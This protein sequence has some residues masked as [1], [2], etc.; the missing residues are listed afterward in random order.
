ME[1]DTLDGAVILRAIRKGAVVI[2][3]AALAGFIVGAFATMA[4]P[5]DYESYATV[6][7]DASVVDQ[8][9]Q[10]GLTSSSQD[11][12]L[13]FEA[14]SDEVMERAGQ[15]VTPALT[16]RE[17]RQLI[18]ASQVGND[19]VIELVART[20]DPQLSADLVNAVA[21]SMLLGRIEDVNAEFDD[22]A[23]SLDARIAELESELAALDNDIGSQ[24]DASLAIE[25]DSV[26]QQLS[27][28]TEIEVRAGQDQTV[29]A[30][31]EIVDQVAALEAELAILD[32]Q[33]ADAS[34]PALSIQRSTLA[35][36]L[37]LLN[38][39]RVRSDL[40]VALPGEV[41]RSGQVPVSPVGT[42][43]VTNGLAL[44]LIFGGLATFGY[45][46]HSRTFVTADEVQ[47]IVG[48]S[49]IASFP[50]A[51][52]LDVDHDSIFDD[53]HSPT[54]DGLRR[55]DLWTRVRG[56][57]RVL[58]VSVGDSPVASKLVR[59]LAVTRRGDSVTRVIDFEREVLG[60]GLD[61][62]GDSGIR[63][64]SVRDLARD[65]SQ[66]PWFIVSP[67]G[68]RA[69]YALEV[70]AMAD[71]VVLVVDAETASFESFRE[72]IELFGTIGVRP[73][74][75]VVLEHR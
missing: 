64:Q 41:L 62:L 34:D 4:M 74:G 35:E 33:I 51:A 6:R 27:L 18:T 73:S 5:S 42:S 28:L 15:I 50:R 20:N 17:T 48:S 54:A 52:I 69:S 3:A 12:G 16:V 38:A 56:A 53:Q 10:T 29:A 58:F 9:S 71:A 65:A 39:L 66:E 19:A 36:Q 72:V 44:A 45:T 23:V 55:I 46:L 26:A 7:L 40:Y 8:L 67:S 31:A 22:V 49:T 25:R 70:G 14:L 11:D 1:R 59:R 30:S 47:R 68:E 2:A 21:N 24:V 32:Q 13:E 43:S 37:S 60:V 61:A 75:A 57:Q 63:L